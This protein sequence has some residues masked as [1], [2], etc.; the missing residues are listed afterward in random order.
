MNAYRAIVDKRDQRA[1]LERPIPD[2]ALR[3]ILQAGRMTGSSRNLEANRFI[4]VRDRQR[5]ASWPRSRATAGAGLSNWR[6]E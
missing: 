4:V 5:V 1:F 2:E 6:A 3:C